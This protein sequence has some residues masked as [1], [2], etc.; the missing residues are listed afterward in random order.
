MRVKHF[1]NF[2]YKRK[3]LGRARSK[4]RMPT[5]HRPVGGTDTPFLFF[6]QPNSSLAS[7]G[8]YPNCCPSS[9]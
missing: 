6:Y 1:A 7:L 4:M 2:F 8:R 5:Y 3:E 9:K